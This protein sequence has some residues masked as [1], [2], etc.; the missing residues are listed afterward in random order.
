MRNVLETEVP[1]PALLEIETRTRCVPRLRRETLS[2]A[3]LRKL[4]SV[5]RDTRTHRRP[6]LRSTV[7]FTM[8]GRVVVTLIVAE[9]RLA[10]ADTAAISASGQPFLVGALVSRQASVASGTPSRS[11]S[12][13]GP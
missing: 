1:R 10:L 4:A 11:E 13:G 12:A 7:I 9:R 8:A 5:R 6:F 3:R 2:V